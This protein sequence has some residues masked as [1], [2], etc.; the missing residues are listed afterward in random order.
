MLSD[1]T[2]EVWHASTRRA[3]KV[4]RCEECT[5]RIEPGETYER[6]GSLY[7]GSW[8]TYRTCAHCVA[9]RRWLEVICGG[10]LSEGVLEDLAEHR[11]EMGASFALLRLIVASSRR[12]RTRSDDLM[13]VEPVERWASE[14]IDAWR[15]KAQRQV[16]AA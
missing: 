10:Y 8:S 15:T 2:S 16:E 3:R 12:W 7:D 4:W 1:E 6:V 5:R 13:P 9:A 14:A 11:W